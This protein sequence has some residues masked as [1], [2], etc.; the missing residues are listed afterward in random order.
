MGELFAQIAT[1]FFLVPLVRERHLARPAKYKTHLEM[2]RVRA[3]MANSVCRDLRARYSQVRARCMSSPCVTQHPIC[4]PAH[5]LING[6]ARIVF[7]FER[8]RNKTTK[9][10][11]MDG[12]LVTPVG[13][14]H[15]KKYL[16]KESLMC[17][18]I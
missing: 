4:S 1:R 6:I 13:A 9:S 12:S 11:T 15:K 2:D 14:E 5:Y 10:T 17:V 8:K 16:I 7:G 3:A 18:R